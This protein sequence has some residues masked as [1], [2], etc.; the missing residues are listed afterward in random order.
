LK[1]IVLISV[2]QPSTNPRLVK[3]ANALQKAG[4]EVCIVYSY[5]TEWAWENDKA[6]FEKADWKAFLAGGS[7]FEQKLRYFFTR[8][9][10]KIVGFI[11]KNITLKFGIAE[12]ARGRAYVELLKKAKSLKADL[13]IAHIQAALPIAVKAAKKHNAKCGFDAEDF[14]RHEVKDELNSYNYK[15]SR[16][17]EDKYVPQVDYITASSPLIAQQY[18]LLYDREVTVLQNVFPKTSASPLIN[19]NQE[20]P[21]KLFWFSQTIGPGRG[22]ETVIKAVQLAKITVELHLLGLCPDD[23]KQ[24]LLQISQAAGIDPDRTYFYNPVQTEAIFEMASK[25]DIGI[26]S[27]TGFCPNNNMA[28]SNKLFT[29]VQC[30]LAVVASNTPAQ[31]AFMQQHAQAG[32]IYNN[33]NELSVILTEYDADRNLLFQTK[34]ESFKIG[35][36]LLNWDVESQKFLSLVRHTLNID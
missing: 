29:Y 13:Y 33:A 10:S 14:H 2:G 30:G 21:L 34:N 26:A 7:P 22:L 5:W 28:L 17:I 15:I 16:Y 27:E 19:N 12:I 31:Y 18:A 24:Q 4:F 9:R 36:T 11:A 6:L 23:Y 3:E 35:Q 1:K 8:F 25:F 20:E 32:K